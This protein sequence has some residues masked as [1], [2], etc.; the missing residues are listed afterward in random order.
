MMLARLLNLLLG[1]LLAI[2]L[3]F[4]GLHLLT[5]AVEQAHAATAEAVDPVFPRGLPHAL[6]EGQCEGPKRC[7]W[8]A[9]HQ[10]NG[11]GHSLIL[12]RHDGDYLAKRITHRRAH[13]LQAAWCE[14]KNVACGY[15]D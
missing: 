1:L 10:G 5:S 2:G 9:R 3:A 4:A 15:A 7:V 14:R 11:K 12:T 8:D 13:R 6:Y